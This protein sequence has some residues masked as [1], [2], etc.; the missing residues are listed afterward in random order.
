VRTGV[1]STPAKS[2][3]DFIIQPGVAK[4]ELRRVMIPNKIK[5][6]TGFHQ[7]DGELGGLGQLKWLQANSLYVWIDKLSTLTN[8]HLGQSLFD[9]VKASA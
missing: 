6:P 1:G 3:R 9:P 4:N 2:E 8:P 5:T 7:A